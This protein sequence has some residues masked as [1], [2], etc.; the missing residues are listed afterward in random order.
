MNKLLFNKPLIAFVSLVCF[1]VMSLYWLS[2][3]Y[4]E[5][6]KFSPDYIY[7]LW[8]TVIYINII[9]IYSMYTE[10]ENKFNI[11]INSDIYFLIGFNII[12]YHIGKFIIIWE[13]SIWIYWYLS[14]II[15]ILIE[16]HLFLKNTHNE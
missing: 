3:I 14:L 2:L 4:P 11:L 7:M 13:S 9:L 8:I 1:F 12:I 6:I 5:Q 10:L 15:G 16:L